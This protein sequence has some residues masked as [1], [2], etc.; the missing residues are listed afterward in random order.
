M[1]EIII[2]T[3]NVSECVS[4]QWDVRTGITVDPSEEAILACLSEIVRLINETGVDV[5]CL[6][7]FPITQ[8]GSDRIAAYIREHTALC[9]Y[10]GID[11]YPSFLMKNGQIGICIFSKYPLTQCDYHPF[12]NPGITKLSR[13]GKLYWSFDKGLITAH[14]T[15]RDQCFTLVTGHAVSFSPFDARAEDYPESFREIENR[16]KALV[17]KNEPVVIIG[18]FNTE[19]LFSILPTLGDYVSD[20]LPGATTIPGLMEGEVFDGGRKLDYCLV[21]PDVTVTKT[22]K[23][24]NFSD[25]F[26]C[27]CHCRL[28]EEV[29]D[30]L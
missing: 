22:E 12:V 6:Q 15:H 3:W 28:S 4:T 21:T 30:V 7:E 18:D 17:G 16:A 20:R 29:S 13:S 27:L 10:H 25:H 11:T 1:N 24:P 8:N 23:I 5:L 2:G 9:H 14:I 19:N 26:L